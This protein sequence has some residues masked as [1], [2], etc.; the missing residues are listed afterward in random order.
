MKVFT[1]VVLDTF[2][3]VDNKFLGH[4]DTCFMG[5]CW[6]HATQLMSHLLNVGLGL[7]KVTKTYQKLVVR[8]NEVSGEITTGQ[9]MSRM[10]ASV[11]ECLSQLLERDDFITMY[12]AEVIKCIS[13]DMEF[14]SFPCMKPAAYKCDADLATWVRIPVAIHSKVWTDKV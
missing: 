10:T 7:A 3:S 8:W 6:S 13:R 12:E 5:M 2:Y 1:L 11:L 14:R 9:E 4:L